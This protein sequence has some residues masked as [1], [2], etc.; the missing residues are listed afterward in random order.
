MIVLLFSSIAQMNLTELLKI[1]RNLWI[2][3]FSLN[4]VGSFLH[5][6]QRLRTL[7]NHSNEK[8]KAS[9]CFY[10]LPL[11][12]IARERFREPC[13]VVHSSTS[14]QNFLRGL[15][16]APSPHGEA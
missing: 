1:Y 2:F 8:I 4:S 12:T 3:Y 14:E 11:T 10:H 7:Q 15:Y 6:D 9:S 16:A 13:C 5:L